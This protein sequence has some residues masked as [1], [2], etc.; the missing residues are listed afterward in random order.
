MGIYIHTVELYSE[1]T[2]NNFPCS[3]GSWNE[4]ALLIGCLRKYVYLYT[5][6]LF[7]GK[8]KL[9]SFLN[10]TQ[11]FSIISLKTGISRVKL[12][13][14][15]IGLQSKDFETAEELSLVVVS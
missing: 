14:L 11:F 10:T 5:L 13:A 9:F 4:F 3:N 12:P 7:H 8:V 15:F 6:K 2:N 1:N